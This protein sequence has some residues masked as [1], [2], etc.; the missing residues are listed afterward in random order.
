M[1][2]LGPLSQEAT[3]SGITLNGV[4]SWAGRNDMVLTSTS[5]NNYGTFSIT[6]DQTIKRGDE[7]NGSLFT[8][9]VGG[10]VTKLTLPR[11]TQTT[12]N[13]PFQQTGGTLSL[14]GLKI[15][16]QGGLS[17]TAGPAPSTW[18]RAAP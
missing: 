14:N 8:N 3:N 9:G 7:D 13:V 11:S 12:I 4:T 1:Q 15:S 5:I 16:F 18:A 2:I 10:T 6:N 17:Q